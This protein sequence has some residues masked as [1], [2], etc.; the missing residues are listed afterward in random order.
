M[1]IWDKIP[2]LFPE[3]TKHPTYIDSIERV[4]KLVDKVIRKGWVTPMRT[5]YL[6]NIALQAAVYHK[7]DSKDLLETETPYDS[8]RND[9][10]EAWNAISIKLKHLTDYQD[11]NMN[12]HADFQKENYLPH[13]DSWKVYTGTFLFIFSTVLYLIL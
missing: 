11:M 3:D 9:L 4:G 6:S 2:G 1:I 12:Y 7:Q 8:K 5:R 10:S 13:P